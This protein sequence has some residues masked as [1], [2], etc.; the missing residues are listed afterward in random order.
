MATGATTSE[1]L[2]LQ[3][4]Q[5]FLLNVVD[6]HFLV[7]ITEI[8][9]GAIRVSFPGKDYPVEGMRVYLEF[10]D[11]AGFDCYPTRVLEGPRPDRDSILLEWPVA[12]RRIQHRTAVRIPTD[13]TVQVRDQVHVRKYDAAVLNLSAG[14]A[15]IRSDA[16]FDFSTTVEVTLSLPGEPAYTAVGQ[17]VHVARP[18]E[19]DRHHPG[20]FLYGLRFISPDPSFERSIGRY[21]TQRLRQM[22]PAQ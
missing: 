21:V 15:L 16:P 19:L 1:D 3:V 22:Y 20:E 17:V 6:E 10:H 5:N 2:R 11:E 12:S 18:A 8:A 7:R 9:D 13:L 14:G 4:G